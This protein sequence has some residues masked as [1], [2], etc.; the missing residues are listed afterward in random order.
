MTPAEIA[1]L[2]ASAAVDKKARDVVTL[3]LQGKTTVADYFVICEGDTDRQVRA[4]ADNIEDACRAS[5]IRP[6]HVAG[7]RDASWAC[8]DYDS[9]IAHVFLPGE[10]VF[11]DLEGLWGMP[12]RR[13]HAG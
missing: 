12:A 13:R 11:Y 6:L 5:G 3:D 1:A 4:I 2:I 8:L 7:L 9:V 10:R